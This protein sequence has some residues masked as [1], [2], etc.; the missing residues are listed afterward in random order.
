MN[1]YISLVSFCFC[2]LNEVTEV[3]E[4]PEATEPNFSNYW[5]IEGLRP[6]IFSGTPG[7]FEA[8]KLRGVDLEV[9]ANFRSRLRSRLY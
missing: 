8:L 7:N 9:E 1:F 4:A 6:T 3:T 2:G 5:K